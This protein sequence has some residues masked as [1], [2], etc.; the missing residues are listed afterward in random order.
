MALTA[1]SVLTDLDARLPQESASWR[2]A[3]LRQVVALFLSNADAYSGEQIALFDEVMSR[4]T[5]KIDRAQ[6]AELSVA[7]AGVS[8][9]PSKLFAGLARHTDPAVCGPVLE[10]WNALPDTALITIVDKDGADPGTLVKIAARSEL[11]ESVTDA[12]IK[13]GN[14]AVRRKVLANPKA[15]ISEMGFARLVSAINGDRAMAAAIAARPE[16]PAEL[17][18]FVDAALGPS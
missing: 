11:S 18:P 14:A 16:M 7:L 4:L 6:L 15:R 3:A 2:G 12:L 13:R 9:A 5:K 8:H 1:Q 17:R 10:R